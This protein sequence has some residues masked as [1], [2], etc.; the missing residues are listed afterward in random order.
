[1]STSAARWKSDVH[2]LIGILTEGE[3]KRAARDNALSFADELVRRGEFDYYDTQRART[4]QLASALG[5]QAVEGALAAN[6]REFDAALRAVKLMLQEF[7]DEQIY[8]D[9]YPPE[10]RDYY[11]SRYEFTQVGDGHCYLYG[12]NAVWGEKIRNDR[13]YE[14]AVT[15]HDNLWVTSMGPHCA[16]PLGAILDYWQESGNS[17]E[18]NC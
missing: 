4:Y 10:E 7:T 15:G 18:S 2:Y 11:A 6:R 9:D 14:S 16:S 17:A 1:L 3:T 8:Q 12:D 13:D 5:K